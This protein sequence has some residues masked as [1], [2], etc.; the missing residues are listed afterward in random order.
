MEE[1]DSI[2]QDTGDSTVNKAFAFMELPFS[3]GRQINTRIGGA[4][5]KWKQDDHEKHGKT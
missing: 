1:T 3:S 4:G 2:F 5:Q